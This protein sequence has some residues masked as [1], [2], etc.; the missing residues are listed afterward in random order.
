MQTG[1]SEDGD[2]YLSSSGAM[3]TGWKYLEPKD[4]DK[5]L[6]GP[7]SDDGKYWFYFSASGK[8]NSPSTSSNGGDYK[9]MKIDGKYYCFDADGCRPDG[10]I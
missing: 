9:V 5:D 4:E 8:K 1:W 10:C 3:V 6:Y 7:E 2:Y